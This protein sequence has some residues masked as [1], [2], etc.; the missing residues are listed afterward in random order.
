MNDELS[1]QKGRLKQL[2]NTAKKLQRDGI[3]TESPALNDR[4]ESVRI[5]ADSLGKRSAEQ[6]G[7]V[8]QVCAPNYRYIIQT[9]RIQYEIHLINNCMYM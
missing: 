6:L 4:L 9:Y 3:I 5:Q 8:E 7:Q 2:T 1:A